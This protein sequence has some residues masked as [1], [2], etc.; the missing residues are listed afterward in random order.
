MFKKRLVSLAKGAGIFVSSLKENRSLELVII[1]NHSKR[2]LHSN[3][4]P[5]QFLNLI[6]GRGIFLEK[7]EPCSVL[8]FELTLLKGH[9]FPAT[10][11][12]VSI[13]EVDFV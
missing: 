11:T 6:V 13:K 7:M 1:S 2:S 3:T 8:L 5:Y 12:G 4:Y 9:V 10:L